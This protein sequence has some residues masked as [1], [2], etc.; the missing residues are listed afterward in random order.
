MLS[1]NKIGEQP[2]SYNQKTAKAVELV[3]KMNRQR[4]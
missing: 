3:K 2:L 1:K 4:K